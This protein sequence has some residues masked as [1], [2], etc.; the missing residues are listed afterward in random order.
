MAIPSYAID[1]GLICLLCARF[2]FV[3]YILYMSTKKWSYMICPECLKECDRKDF[4]MGNKTCYRCVYQ[5]K[6]GKTKS[7]EIKKIYCRICESE[8]II[9]KSTKQRHRTIFCSEACYI[10]GRKNQCR[11]HWTRKLREVVPLYQQ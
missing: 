2:D 4:L 1:N 3:E 6:K 7:K 11:D 5:K 8:I 9:D 10:I